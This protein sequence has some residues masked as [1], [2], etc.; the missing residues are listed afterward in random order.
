MEDATGRV[1]V[2]SSTYFAH[3]H[4]RTHTRTHTMIY[5]RPI[6]N[7][8]SVGIARIELYRTK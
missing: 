6:S 7:L 8:L 3:R 5:Q 4:T 1:R 2:V